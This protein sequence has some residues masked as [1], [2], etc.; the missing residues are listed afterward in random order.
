MSCL[1]L[2]VV[3][4]SAK[5]F[6]RQIC[7]PT[8]FCL[9]HFFTHNLMAA[10]IPTDTSSMKPWYKHHIPLDKYQ[11][12]KIK[13]LAEKELNVKVTEVAFRMSIQ[14]AIQNTLGLAGTGLKIDVLDWNPTTCT[15]IVKVPQKELVVIWGSLVTHQFAMAD[16]VCTLDIVD[17][18]ASLISLAD[19]S[20][21][22]SF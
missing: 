13:L 6:P 15:G 9:S 1:I 10:S 19:N 5:K 4:M 18:S 2:D 21:D 11:Y 22:E 20:R 8:I 17:N 14:Q 7:H 12:L 16:Q 3:S